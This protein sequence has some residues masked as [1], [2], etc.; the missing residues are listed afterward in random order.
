MST[1]PERILYTFKISHYAEKARWA[2]DR[3][4]LPYREHA[5]LLGPGQVLLKLRTGSRQVPVLDDGGH[6]V[7]GSTAILEH[8][9]R[10]YPTAPLWPEDPAERAEAKSLVE[11]IDERIGKGVRGYLLAQARNNRRLGAGA[12]VAKV[13]G[14][15]VLGVA[16]DYF[17]FESLDRAQEEFPRD[18]RELAARL[19]GR[20][21]LIGNRFGAADL[22]AA[23][24]LNGLYAPQGS[25][26][27]TRFNSHRP[28]LAKDRELVPFFDWLD[29][30]YRDHRRAR[31]VADYGTPSDAA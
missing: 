10:R 25:P 3:K 15:A 19:V 5:V 11:W 13:V 7:P 31:P 22:T 1:H 28:G 16:S 18:L 27:R 2:L 26:L 30:M 14:P 21:F 23:S 12:K 9:D 4:A 24:L 29:R 6:V 8:L 17:G 20:D